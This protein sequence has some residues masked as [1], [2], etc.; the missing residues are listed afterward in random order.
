MLG[1]ALWGADVQA[2]ES[3]GHWR[4]TYD[5]TMRWINFLILVGVIVKYARVPIK[6]FLK[7]R[8]ADVEA[9]I[10]QLEKE[11]SEV[12]ARVSTLVKEGE[13]SQAQLAELKERLLADGQRRKREIIEEAK[14]HSLLIIEE[15]KR[16]VEYQIL[17]ARQQFKEALVD[18]AADLALKRLPVEVKAAD[19]EMMLGLFL[20]G[21]ENQGRTIARVAK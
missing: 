3:A 1:L 17:K 4:E 18:A 12:V 5:L 8:K 7:M 20:Q 16:K 6:N 11:K 9:E 2:A 19:Q 14:A 10:V 13:D 21:I 15:A